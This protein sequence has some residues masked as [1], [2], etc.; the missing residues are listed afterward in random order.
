MSEVRAGFLGTL[1]SELDDSDE[2]YSLD[3]AFEQL[4]ILHG[5]ARSAYLEFRLRP[6]KAAALF[7]MLRLQGSDGQEWTVGPTSGMW[8][9]R[10]VGASEWIRASTPVGLTAV[11]DQE[12]EWLRDGIGAYLIDHGADPDAEREES[13][14]TAAA[15]SYGSDF[16]HGLVNPFADLQETQQ[17]TTSGKK[18]EFGKK[19]E[20]T[21]WLLEEWAE[22]DQSL[23]Q[24]RSMRSA[25][26]PSVGRPELPK[27]LPADWD[28]DRV[29]AEAAEAS[30]APV[31]RADS[32]PEDP[33]WQPQ[34]LEGYVNP[35]SF[36]LPPEE[37]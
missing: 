7:K 8:Y 24:L 19:G 17:R 33:S 25:D 22:F 32:Q 11:Y 28:A 2:D 5:A 1:K 35:E 37:Q 23:E 31:G 4:S 6:D 12:P 15:S 10:G 36:F 27:N 34:E 30:D 16:E 14:A 26:A 21:D 9:R 29:M 20:D 18:M 13:R 3:P